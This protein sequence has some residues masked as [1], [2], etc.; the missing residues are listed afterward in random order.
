MPT[1]RTAMNAIRP[2]HTPLMPQPNCS[3]ARLMRGERPQRGD[4][5]D[6]PEE[7]D[8]T[9][10]D[11]HTVQ[12][13]HHAGER[14]HRD[15]PGPQQMSLMEHGRIRGEDPRDEAPAQLRGRPRTRHPPTG[16]SAP[17]A[18]PSYGRRRRP[19]RP[20]PHRPATVRRWRRSRGAG[21][22]TPRAEARSDAPRSARSPSALRPPAAVRNATWKP[23]DL[24]KRSRPTTSCCRMTWRCGLI[25]AS[26]ALC[27]ART[28]SSE[29]MT[30]APTLAMAEPSSP[31]PAG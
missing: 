6:G 23:T 2:A 31:S 20:G 9:R 12:R 7:R 5:G 22:R 28:K 19:I 4:Q 14:Q 26:A 24:R 10:T 17:P 1:K 8:V 30:C 3:A 11:E 25:R 13:E 29:P 27:S 21:R 16:H 15:E 18:R